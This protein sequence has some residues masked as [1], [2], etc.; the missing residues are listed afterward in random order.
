MARSMKIFKGVLSMP[1]GTNEIVTVTKSGRIAI[2]KA[3]STN[4]KRPS[5][6]H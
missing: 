1:I 2:S 6:K 5:K 3:N 4:V